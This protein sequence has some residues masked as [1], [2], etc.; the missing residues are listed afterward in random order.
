MAERIYAWFVAFFAALSVFGLYLGFGNMIYVHTALAAIVLAAGVAFYAAMNYGING[1]VNVTT[2][3]AQ[4][5]KYRIHIIVL[6][7][8]FGIALFYPMAESLVFPNA[9]SD[10]EFHSL[11]ARFIAV[12]HGFVVLNLGVLYDNHNL[13]NVVPAMFYLFHQNIYRILSVLGWIFSIMIAYSVYLVSRTL[14]NEKI[15]LVSAF[16]SAFSITNLWIMDQGYIPQLYGTM[17]FF[18]CTYFFMTKRN[19]H[20]FLAGAGLMSYPHFF[21]AFMIFLFLEA[22]PIRNFKENFKLPILSMLLVAPHIFGIVSNFLL[23]YEF[24]NFLLIKGGIMTPPL[25][26]L[27][28]FAFAIP[29]IF[30]LFKDLRGRNRTLFNLA[31]GVS[32]VPAFIL[33]VLAVNYFVRF[34]LVNIYQLYIIVKMF[35]LALNVIGII[36]AVG[37]FYLM[38]ATKGKGLRTYAALALVASVMIFHFA[39][40][41]NYAYIDR[42]RGNFNPAVYDAVAALNK[43]HGEF[44]VGIDGCMLAN[45]WMQSF[46]YNSFYDVP[47]DYMACP[48]REIN[49]TFRPDWV[50]AD[51]PTVNSRN[52]S[53]VLVGKEGADYFVT[54]CSSV[55]APIFYEKGG[56]KVYKL[57]N[58]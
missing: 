53:V 26:S 29:G 42:E 12:T 6:L 31:F 37:V 19:M 52:E 24:K 39:Y 57:S 45:N 17:F 4:A 30:A 33:A 38:S 14:F 44:K 9:C 25:W 15:A 16:I 35:Y 46:P 18:A 47:N 1:I 10:M 21:L 8:A 11:A 49:S 56:I 3:K 36:A 41:A 28:A 54:D 34:T 51:G 2:E 40:F 5:E 48:Q 50:K 22:L 20:L 58:G 13:F 7:A 55:D 27:A 23:D 43:I 32:A